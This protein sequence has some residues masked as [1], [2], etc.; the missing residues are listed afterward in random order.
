MST[1]DWLSQN[2][3][4]SLHDKLAMC[5]ARYS[6][7]SN[8]AIICPSR[9]GPLLETGLFSLTGSWLHG[10]TTFPAPHVSGLVR[11]LPSVKA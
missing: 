6:I 9:M 1:A 2:I 10:Q 4:N 11:Q 5:W 7:S 3:F 8:I